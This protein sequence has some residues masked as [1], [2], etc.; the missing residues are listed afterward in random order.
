MVRA[1]PRPQDDADHQRE[2]YAT[3]LNQLLMNFLDSSVGRCG[4][5]RGG[6]GRGWLLGVLG[7]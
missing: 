5:V 6:A 7:R 3:I 2:L 4:A 1:P